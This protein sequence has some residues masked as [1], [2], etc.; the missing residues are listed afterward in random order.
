MIQN[1]TKP[2]LGLQLKRFYRQ[3]LL[4]EVAAFCWGRHS[5]FLWAVLLRSNPM[6]SVP[7]GRRFVC[8]H[9][10]NFG[11][12]E[13]SERIR[14]WM[15]RI[16]LVSHLKT[17]FQYRAHELCKML[18][19]FMNPLL[20]WH[21]PLDIPRDCVIPSNSS[22]SALRGDEIHFQFAWGHSG[23]SFFAHEIFIS[24]KKYQNG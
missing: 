10:S 6:F 22:T 17:C 18:P 9:P 1:K 15:S 20:A 21:M 7:W 3:H 14:C 23:Y 5:I 4:C 16:G 13:Q 2:L 12:Y 11:S 24:L 19:P 8:L